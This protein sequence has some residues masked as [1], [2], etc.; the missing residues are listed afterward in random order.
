MGSLDASF[1]RLPNMDHPKN[2]RSRG[3]RRGPIGVFIDLLR[4]RCGQH[5]WSSTDRLFHTDQLAFDHAPTLDLKRAISHATLHTS[6]RSNGDVFMNFDRVA[7]GASNVGLGGAD[8]A[9]DF[10]GHT[11]KDLIGFDLTVDH[12][13][14]E[15]GARQGNLT[16]DGDPLADEETTFRVLA[17]HDGRPEAFWFYVIR[18]LPYWI[19]FKD[20]TCNI[21]CILTSVSGLLRRKK[22]RTVIGENTV[23]HGSL[24]FAHDAH[25][26]GTVLGHVLPSQPQRPCR[27]SVDRSAVIHG[28]V[29]ASDI[30][31]RGRVHGDVGAQKTL[32]L[33]AD[34]QV[35]GQLNYRD[36]TIETE[37]PTPP[38]PAA[39]A[40]SEPLKSLD[41]R[42]EGILRVL[43]EP[44]RNPR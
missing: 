28:A 16:I 25:I 34:A 5:G 4:G 37:P 18:T 12:A 43:R 26:A 27:L 29:A 23:I 33:G 1:L 22:I 2:S 30:E 13:V 41:P 11:Y 10:T 31:L 39:P 17:F 32:V 35:F 20:A 9:I 3:R 14:D 8:R 40:V 15:Y 19:N 38:A 24:R 6:T 36:I 21:I 42:F 44:W 7:D